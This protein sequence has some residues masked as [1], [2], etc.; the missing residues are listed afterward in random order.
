[1]TTTTA[2]PAATGCN[3]SYAFT[4][5]PRAP[6]L[7]RQPSKSYLSGTPPP[8]RFRND[9]ATSVQRDPAAVVVVSDFADG[10][11]AD[12]LRILGHEDGFGFHDQPF[13]EES[14]GLGHNAD[15]FSWHARPP[16]KPATA[17]AHRYRTEGTAMSQKANRIAAAM[18]SIALIVAVSGCQKQE[19]P[20]E[21]AGKQVDKAV[22]KTGQQIE[23]AGD[24]IQ[25]AA[26]K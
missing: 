13:L 12:A 16:G 17:Q 10:C 14:V 5:A 25:D 4:Q 22:E 1:M 18:A 3:A 15:A 6:W 7:N 21:R 24:K 11:G 2:A 20:A 26:K 9:C 19:G 8:S 23:K